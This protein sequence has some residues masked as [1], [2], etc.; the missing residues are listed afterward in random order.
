MNTLSR[1]GLNRWLAAPVPM[2]LMQK[3]G[4][5]SNRAHRFQPEHHRK[6][7]YPLVEGR[8]FI[9]IGGTS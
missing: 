8:D 1:T 3:M 2:V 5:M 9:R 4:R 7:R 6:L